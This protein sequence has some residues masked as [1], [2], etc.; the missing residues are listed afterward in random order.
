MCCFALFF[1]L[2]FFSVLSFAL[3]RAV[4]RSVGLSVCCCSLA[5]SRFTFGARPGWAE[6]VK[7]GRPKSLRTE[8]ASCTRCCE[9]KILRLLSCLFLASLVALSGWEWSRVGTLGTLTS[10]G[11]SCSSQSH[12]G[13]VMTGD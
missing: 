6:G 2:A 9:T 7:N 13:C 12:G 11:N 5:P 8:R 3:C 1:F 10:V 4:C